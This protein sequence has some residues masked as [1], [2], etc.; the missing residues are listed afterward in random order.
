MCFGNDMNIQK[1][2]QDGRNQKE[3]KQ[4]IGAEART[5]ANQSNT[6]A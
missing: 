2:K 5:Y 1:G 6:K 4:T 3:T